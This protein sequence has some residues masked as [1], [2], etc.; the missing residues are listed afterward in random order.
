MFFWCN[1]NMME[2]ALTK[3]GEIK[4]PS[5]ESEALY[6]YG[7]IWTGKKRLI[8]LICGRQF[9]PYAKK[10]KVTGKPVCNECAK[11]MNV[12]K[13]EGEV[14]RFRC[15]GYPECKNIRKFMIKE[16]KEES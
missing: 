16:I 12:Y 4:C 15:S 8:C 1:K 5:C 6:K 3:G 14:V 10:F 2:L 9:T 7:K 13:L 11:P